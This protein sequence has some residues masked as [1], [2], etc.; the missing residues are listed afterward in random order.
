MF[1][2]INQIFRPKGKLEIGNF[3][4]EQNKEEL[5][6]K[7]NIKLEDCHKNEDGKYFITDT[8]HKLEILSTHYKN[9][10]EQ[11]DNMGKPGLTSIVNHKTDEIKNEIL[12]DERIGKTLTTFTNNNKATNPIE[13]CDYFSNYTE[14]HIIFKKLNNKKSSG[15]D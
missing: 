14:T 12:E 2:I 7:S 13:N 5:I 4:L 11:N 8:K 10:Y 6:T 1:P 15:P 9:I 3:L